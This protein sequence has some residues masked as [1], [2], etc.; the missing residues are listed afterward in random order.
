MLLRPANPAELQAIAALMNLAY[1]GTD[2]TLS[3]NT[4]APYIQGIRTSEEALRQDLA[5]NPQ[6]TLLVHTEPEAGSKEAPIQASVWL[7]PK[8]PARWYLGALTV[9]PALQSAGLGGQLL[10]AAEQWAAERGATTI[11]MSVVNVRD[12]LIAWYQRRGYQ[13]T[14]ETHPFPYGDSRFG[15][16]LRDD[17]AFLVLEKHLPT[18]L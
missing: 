17:L 15:T 18:T 7:E 12:T 8:T 1:R 14:G 4:E 5:T 13:L 9:D 10:T 3:W 6:A 16:P 2:A 11:E